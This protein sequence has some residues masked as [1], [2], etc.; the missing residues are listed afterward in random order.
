MASAVNDANVELSRRIALARE[1]RQ[2]LQHVTSPVAAP[3]SPLRQYGSSHEND[4]SSI[5]EQLAAIRQKSSSLRSSMQKAVASPKMSSSDDGT[6]GEPHSYCS[7][8]SPMK[9]STNTN[10]S[11]SSS[12]RGG[13]D[14]TGIAPLESSGQDPQV[15]TMSH[16]TAHHNDATRQTVGLD[17]VHTS[18]ADSSDEPRATNGIRPNA[19]AAPPAPHT[20][21]MEGLDKRIAAMRQR[22]ARL[23]QAL[24]RDD[25]VT[26]PSDAATDTLGG[27]QSVVMQTHTLHPH[28]STPSAQTDAD[29]PAS[30]RT[31]THPPAPPAHRLQPSANHLEAEVARLEAQVAAADAELCANKATLERALQTVAK[32]EHS[33]RDER[34]RLDAAKA[35]TRRTAEARE[36]KTAKGAVALSKSTSS[37]PTRKSTGSKSDRKKKS[38]SK[39]VAPFAGTR[40]TSVGSGPRTKGG[41]RPPKAKT[42]KKSQAL[43]ASASPTVTP[44]TATPQSAVPADDT[45]DDA[46]DMSRQVDR[47]PPLATPVAFR[48]LHDYNPT[49]ES[50]NPDPHLEL[51]LHANEII[52]VVSELCSDG[53]YMAERVNPADGQT[54]QGLVAYTYLTPLDDTNVNPTPGATDAASAHDETVERA[55]APESTPAPSTDE[56][57][58]VVDDLSEAEKQQAEAHVDYVVVGRLTEKE[59]LQAHRIATA[60]A[61]RAASAQAAP[62]MTSPRAREATARRTRSPPHKTAPVRAVVPK[63][64]DHDADEDGRRAA[65]ERLRAAKRPQGIARDAQIS[66]SLTELQDKYSLTIKNV[67][68]KKVYGAAK[69]PTEKFEINGVETISVMRKSDLILVKDGNAWVPVRKFFRKYSPDV[70]APHVAAE[71]PDVLEARRLEAMVQSAQREVEIVAENY[72]SKVDVEK[73]RVALLKEQIAASKDHLHKETAEENRLLVEMQ[74]QNA[75]LQEQLLRKSQPVASAHDGSSSLSRS[76]PVALTSSTPLSLRLPNKIKRKLTIDEAISAAIAKALDKYPDAIIRPTKTKAHGNFRT[77]LINGESVLMTQKGNR[78]LVRGKSDWKH[79]DEF[80]S[81]QKERLAAD[82]EK[83]ERIEAGIK[84]KIEGKKLAASL[85]EKEN[86]EQRYRRLALAYEKTKERCETTHKQGALELA[87]T[88][89]TVEELEQEMAQIDEI[90]RAAR[91]RRLELLEHMQQKNDSLLSKLDNADEQVAAENDSALSAN[92]SQLSSTFKENTTAAIE[93]CNAYEGLKAELEAEIGGGRIAA[94]ADDVPS[95]ASLMDTS[96]ASSHTDDYAPPTSSIPVLT[97]PATTVKSP[98]RSG[99]PR[100]KPQSKKKKKK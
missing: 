1:Q 65:A 33:V 85:I 90:Q 13:A 67:P 39:G 70:S 16:L 51:T 18:A 9:T 42:A 96:T 54:E 69:A 76:L 19:T 62:A 88:Q 36:T 63:D 98:N 74:T 4:L 92:D 23:R 57:F 14:G 72:H 71:H 99:K 75:E 94:S 12:P 43:S 15:L 47:A 95:D 59:A 32:F 45:A 84:S 73:A 64:A 53:F 93:A 66:A 91:E 30:S 10:P 22:S 55:S 44:S 35:V 2:S 31:A 6:G 77:F 78:V 60:Q 27:Q 48:V 56:A 34:E 52:H 81:Q 87:K 25:P 86:K 21:E 20:Q 5:S 17:G 8:E 89:R 80:L 49:E 50:P 68:P 28:D 26:A 29:V 38:S 61:Q 79:L 82:V 24:A 100:A 11:Q 3:V 46:N 7:G 37:I 97:A 58:V 83:R 40:S 41:E